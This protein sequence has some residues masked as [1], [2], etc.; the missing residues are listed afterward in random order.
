[1]ARKTY[2]F[3][4]T[5]RRNEFALPSRSLTLGRLEPVQLTP[6]NDPYQLWFG[7]LTRET[8]SKMALWVRLDL[9][10]RVL[11]I[12]I[13]PWH[14]WKTAREYRNQLRLPTHKAILDALLLRLD[15]N[16]RFIRTR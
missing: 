15:S 9:N 7:A 4:H 8:F 1:M 5:R 10:Q 6:K 16:Q 12:L 14:F 3:I 11:Y 2:F 13:A